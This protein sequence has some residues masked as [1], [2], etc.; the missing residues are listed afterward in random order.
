MKATG[1]T[2]G[3]GKENE[4]SAKDVAAIAAILLEAYP[5]EILE[6]TNQPSYYIP[7]Y[8]I[9]IFTTNKMLLENE[10]V[11]LKELDGLKT[12]YTVS[13]GYGFVGTAA[14]KDKL[15]ITV[16]MNVENEEKRFIETKKLLNYGF[17]K[18]SIIN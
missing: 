5:S 7:I 11:Y 13:A 9:N 15:L 4:M 10:A 12:G 18:F 3:K 14:N 17:D 16:I 8:D 1:L 2:D 6:I